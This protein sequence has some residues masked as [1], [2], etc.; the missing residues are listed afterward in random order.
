[1]LVMTRH[2]YVS[3]IW[4]LVIP[5]PQRHLKSE[6]DEQP[7]CVKLA[8]KHGLRQPGRPSRGSSAIAN[9]AKD[10]H[11]IRLG[12]IFAVCDCCVARRR[13]RCV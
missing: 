12:F 8:S 7:D 13:L 4:P 2:L 10:S 6:V 1:M 9:M 11:R 5:Y 3:S